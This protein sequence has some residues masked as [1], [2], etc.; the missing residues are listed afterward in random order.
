MCQPLFRGVDR[1]SLRNLT[2]RV[3]EIS[4]RSGQ[5]LATPNDAGESHVA[6]D[7][8]LDL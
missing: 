8:G 2:L 1:S 5:N 4:R 3:L 7:C 6:L